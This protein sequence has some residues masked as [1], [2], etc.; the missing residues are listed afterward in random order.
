[1]KVTAGNVSFKQFFETC[2][3]KFGVR[4]F[5]TSLESSDG[6]ILEDDDG[7]VY[8]RD[9]NLEVL[10]IERLELKVNLGFLMLFIHSFF[11]FNSDE[12]SNF[13]SDG[14]CRPSSS[15]ENR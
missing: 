4:L 14:S 9:N 8:V 7:M 10:V 5:G 11:I 3:S 13:N 12:F 15:N 1:M 2:C 6:V